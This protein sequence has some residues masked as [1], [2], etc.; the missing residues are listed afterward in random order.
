MHNR[1]SS[2]Q[3]TK[4]KHAST[5]DAYQVSV[6]PVEDRR[7]F[8]IAS[9]KFLKEV[10]YEFDFRRAYEDFMLKCLNHY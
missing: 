6:D 9:Y 5:D 2:F 4:F 1:S 8:T 10:C 7:T 3:K